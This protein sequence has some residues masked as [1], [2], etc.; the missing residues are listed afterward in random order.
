MDSLIQVIGK[1]MKNMEREFIVGRME[2]N[3]MVSTKM[4][5]EKDMELCITRMVKY[6]KEI[7]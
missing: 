7:G 6:T 4:E 2:I 3:M 1:V 5:K